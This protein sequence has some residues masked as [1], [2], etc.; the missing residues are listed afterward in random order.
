M[1][2]YETNKFRSGIKIIYHG[3]PC[4]ILTSEF[5]KPGKGQAFN[6]V[7]LR[8]LISGGVFE[9]NFKSGE[10]VVIA[11]VVEIK[12]SYL[13]TDGNLWYFINNENFEQISVT[14][15]VVG[16]HVRWL[17]PQ[18]SYILTFW[19]GNPIVLNVPNFVNLKVVETEPGLK[20]DT[21]NTGNKLACLSTGA[22]IKVPLFINIGNI[23][24]VDTRSGEYISRY[25]ESEMEKKPV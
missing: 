23:V 8:K 12:L 10:Y 1:I 24:R 7:R 15:S 17:V 4:V 3:E 16:D 18:N 20:G 9:K 25:K 13:Y 22:R 14:K 5:I 6:R 11:D 21:V 2:L 19:N